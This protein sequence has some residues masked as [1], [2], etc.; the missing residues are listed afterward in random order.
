MSK[1]WRKIAHLLFRRRFDRDLEDE[2]R[3]HLEMKAR[4]GG[5]TQDA[6]YAAR[7]QFGNA[8]S[9]R[10]ESRD[11]WGWRWIDRLVQ[12][13]RYGARMLVHNPSFTLI[14]VLTLAVGIGVNT[15]IFTA[16][17]AVALRPLDVPDAERVVEVST[18][19]HEN[20][21]Y[22]DYVQIR[23]RS[24]A[25]SGLIAESSANLSMRGAPAVSSKKPGGIAS[26][27][28]FSVPDPVMGKRAD[29]VFAF[30]VTANY[31]RVLR[32]APVMG[33]DFI[34]GE[35]DKPG[36][37]PV[38][39][40]S[41]NYW[42]Q[43]FDRDPGVLGRTLIMNEVAFT[44]IGITPR[45]FVG[46]GPMVPPVWIPIAMRDRLLP[47]TDLLHDRKN[48]CCALFGR[49][50]DD[51]NQQKAQAETD[52]LFQTAKEQKAREDAITKQDSR[53]I[54][55]RVASPFGQTEGLAAPTA[56]VLAAVSLVLLIACANVASLLLARS[57]ARQKEIAIRLAIGA[58]RSRL[59]RQ[60][61][62][63]SVLI[64][65][66]AGSFGLLL[67]WWAVH[68]LMVQISE[69]F[70]G[71]WV[72]FAVHLAPDFRVFGYMLLVSMAAAVGFALVP[73]LQSSRPNLTSALK[74]E[75]ESM[76]GLRK[77]GLRDLLV[78][79]Q[80]AVSLVL[81]IAAGLLARG[82]QRAFGI[83]PG[84][85]YRHLIEFHFVKQAGML[86]PAKAQSVQRRVI[87]RME[88][89]PGVRAVSVASRVPLM[90]EM[91]TVSVGVD[92][93]PVDP[94]HAPECHYGMVT[95]NFFETVGIPIVRGRNFT[96]Q[97]TR[98]GD[99]F[100]GASVVISENTARK[101]WPGQDPIGKRIS[102]E[103]ADKEDDETNPRS[104]SSLVT[105]VAK[106]IRGLQIDKV[107]DTFLYLPVTPDF[108]GRIVLR[109]TG[110]TRPVVAALHRE[111]PEVDPDFEAFMF[112]YRWDFSMQP[113]VFLSRVAA[114][115]ATIIGFLGL[116][117]ASVGIYGMV[118]FAV[119]QR[120][121]EVGIRMALGADRGDV[122]K[123]VLS[124]SMRPVLV[125]I[126]A[127]IVAAAGAGRVLVSLLFGLSTFDPPTFLGVS[128]ILAAVALVAGYIPARRA[129]KVDPMVALRYG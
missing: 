117:M 73:A 50:A 36:A 123:L 92:G 112:D 46:T 101:L 49:L 8:T 45:N 88:A 43:R 83:D 15:A 64:S 69:T 2:M 14:A 12:D 129:T 20:F 87:A 29:H 7:R 74:D 82:S 38:L 62:T 11:E 118:S 75:G 113:M 80:V 89:M 67:A 21:S 34:P 107:D 9:L 53:H 47:G 121:H 6:D 16:F 41:E 4:A 105:G 95:P 120:T 70:S 100:N 19:S 23:D 18:T 81:L 44:I 109:T 84:F 25:F 122:L 94:R 71:L 33:R 22:P 48:T 65:V 125:G 108:P 119:S 72:T 26:A 116:A 57:T 103:T 30:L 106:D 10:E 24:H 37:H 39:M 111:L 28:G 54:A 91:R 128:A 68:L 61:M 124:Q 32:A 85:D 78:A 35:D 86:D 115:L 58:N 102:F 55:L 1:L 5:G 42:E 79:I 90:G 93:R 96:E 3:F 98:T 60:L 31:L 52:G 110:D 77:S 97:D 114:I 13:L 126:G 17:N 40:L 56:F 104:R 63:E 51:V 127:G 59:L 76:G 99:N 27:M 66:L